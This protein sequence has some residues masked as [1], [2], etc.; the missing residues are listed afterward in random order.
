MKN[1]KTQLSI[2][3][4]MFSATLFGQVGINTTDPQVTL[5]VQGKPSDSK[6]L[7]GVLLPRVTASELKLKIYSTNHKGTLI[8]VTEAFSNAADANGQVE[9]VTTPGTYQFDGTKW[10]SYSLEEKDTLNS[11]V[12]RGKHT[13][14]SISFGNTA[15][16][17]FLGANSENENIFFINRD[18]D[19][20]SDLI[21]KYNLGIGMYSLY[22]LTEGKSNSSYGNYSLSSLKK[23]NSNSA[24]GVNTGYFLEGN[25]NSLFGLSAGENATTT[26]WNSIFGSG[27]GKYLSTGYKN[28]FFGGG[29]AQRNNI[30]SLNFVAGYSAASTGDIGDR[31]III[32]PYAGNSVTGT[33]PVG[34]NNILIGLGAGYNDSSLQNKLIIH[35]NSAL[36]GYS[37]TSEGNFTPAGAFAQSNLQNGLITGDFVDRWVK[38]NGKFQINPSYMPAATS[39]FSSVLLQNP[40]TGDVGVSTLSNVISNAG[41]VLV[42]TPPTTGNYILESNNGTMT[43]VAK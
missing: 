41:I 34:N 19:L 9:F 15:S 2:L 42:P 11:V 6:S 20:R 18:L 33:K 26:S 10:Q 4:I 3:A 21:G 22:S 38:F 14:K 16:P 32:G 39:D 37:A 43:W 7:D 28:S 1:K 12:L 17:F 35:S 8:Y 29:S 27:S 23:G 30:G 5:D 25:F 36:S 13:T 31:N 24:F 40:T